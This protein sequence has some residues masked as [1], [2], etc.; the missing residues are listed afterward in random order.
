MANTAAPMVLLGARVKLS[1]TE[2]NWPWWLIASG[3]AERLTEPPSHQ[4]GRRPNRL[5]VV[6][7]PARIALARA[8]GLARL[9]ADS[10]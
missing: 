5:A 3:A 1:V 9:G 6:A 7:Q 10:A 8:E 2:G 4:P